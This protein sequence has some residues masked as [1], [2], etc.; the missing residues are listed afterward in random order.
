MELL[1][2][3]S[4]SFGGKLAIGSFSVKIDKFWSNFY[5]KDKNT[6]PPVY[7]S[8]FSSLSSVSLRISLQ[9]IGTRQ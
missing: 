3:K 4:L 1:A 5:E 9:Q 8:S 2:I 7:L 6:S